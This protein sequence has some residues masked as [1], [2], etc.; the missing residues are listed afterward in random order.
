VFVEKVEDCI[1]GFS[2]AKRVNDYMCIKE[3]MEHISVQVAEFKQ[4]F[5][6]KYLKKTQFLTIIKNIILNDLI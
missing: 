5:D 4:K 1:P 3:N 2:I 6:K